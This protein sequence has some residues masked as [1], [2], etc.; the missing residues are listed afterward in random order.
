MVFIGRMSNKIVASMARLIC[1]QRFLV[2]V[3][4][5]LDASMCLDCRFASETDIMTLN[6]RQTIRKCLRGD[7]DNWVTISTKAAYLEA[8]TDLSLPKEEKE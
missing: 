5:L 7:C 3:I 1:L 2:R 8:T 6:G 4:E